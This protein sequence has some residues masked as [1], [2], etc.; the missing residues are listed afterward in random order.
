MANPYVGEI[1]MVGFNFNPVG[2]ALCNGQL[3][4]I[5][6][7]ATLYNLIGTTYGGDGVNTFALP[8]LQGRIAMHQGNGHVLGELAGVEAVTLTTGQLP[9]HTHV[10][11]CNSGDGNS[12]NPSGNFC[13]N[14]FAKATNVYS[15]K[16]PDSTM[17]AG[18]SG[19]AGGSQPHNNIQPILCV[20][21]V[22]SLFGIY[23]SQS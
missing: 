22:I 17:A 12:R 15:D 6:Q 21:F 11:A 14:E 3:L 19:L 10:P 16:P 7:Y 18:A 23:P 1:R 8:N 20:N 5:A 4:S 2:W 9:A 13:A